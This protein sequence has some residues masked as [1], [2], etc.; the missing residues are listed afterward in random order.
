MRVSSESMIVLGALLLAV[1]MAGQESRNEWK[2]TY[3]RTPGMVNFGIQRTR[4][5]NRNSY[6]SDV[7][8]S[9]FRGLKYMN[10]PQAK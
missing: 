1:L 10:S 5:G 3:S 9:A 7:P 2:L 8:L 4:P 6:S